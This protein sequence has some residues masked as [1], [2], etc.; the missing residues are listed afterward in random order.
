MGITFREAMLSLAKTFS[1]SSKWSPV[2]DKGNYTRELKH[3]FK[4][5]LTTYN[6]PTPKKKLQ[7]VIIL[8]LMRCMAQSTTFLVINQHRRSHNRPHNQVLF[9]YYEIMQIFKDSKPGKDRAN[10]SR[11]IKFLHS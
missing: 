7:T 8:D 10:Y 5:L 6:N 1:N 9:F 2:H 11:L 4:D 3:I